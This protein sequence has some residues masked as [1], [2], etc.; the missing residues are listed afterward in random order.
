MLERWNGLGGV[1]DLE[2]IIGKIKLLPK[3]VGWEMSKSDNPETI[4]YVQLE[5]VIQLL[6]D[7]SKE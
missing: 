3:M 6:R 4:E 5:Q 1:V 7:N 2:N